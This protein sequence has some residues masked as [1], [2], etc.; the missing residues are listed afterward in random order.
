MLLTGFPLLFCLILLSALFALLLLAI[1]QLVQFKAPS[2]LKEATYESGM[3][4]YGDARV[5]FDV[6]FYLYALMFIL[7]DIETVFLF[8]WAVTFDQMGVFAFVEMLVFL[9]ILTVGLVYAWRKGALS[10]Q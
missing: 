7:F 2:Q 5:R 10:W 6:K 3:T 4:P 8:P 9:G 1:A